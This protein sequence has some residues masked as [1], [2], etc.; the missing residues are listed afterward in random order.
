MGFEPSNDTRS[1]QESLKD[2]RNQNIERERARLN[3]QKASQLEAR[4]A[5]CRINPEA[6]SDCADILGTDG[7]GLKKGPTKRTWTGAALKGGLQKIKEVGGQALDKLDNDITYEIDRLASGGDEEKIKE[8][9]RQRAAREAKLKQIDEGFAKDKSVGAEAIRAVPYV[10]ERLV[11]AVPDLAVMGA[12]L[13]QSTVMKM[14]GQEVDPRDNPF[15]PEYQ[16]PTPRNFEGPQ[17]DVG[18]AVADLTTFVAGTIAVSRRLPEIGKDLA[19]KNRNVLDKF[20]RTEAGGAIA[21]FMLVGPEDDTLSTTI[22]KL[23]PEGPLRDAFSLLAT[24]DD[25]G[26]IQ[27][28][29]K[30][31]AEGV[32]IGGIAGAGIGALGKLAEKAGLAKIASGAEGLLAG[33][34]AARKALKEGATPEEALAKGVKATEAVADKV[35]KEQM[36][37]AVTENVTFTKVA[38]NRA[39]TLTGQKEAAERELKGLL[40]E[41]Q[42]MRADPADPWNQSADEIASKMKELEVKIKKLDTQIA[43]EKNR[44]YNGYGVADD[45]LDASDRAANMT[46]PKTP[47]QIAS[48]FKATARGERGQNIL[49]D[50]GIASIVNASDDPELTSRTLKFVQAQVEKDDTILSDPTV[51]AEADYF[52]KNL[53][54]D[55]AIDGM[56]LETFVKSRGL[57]QTEGTLTPAGVLMSRKLLAD[58]SGD[59]YENLKS[60]MELDSQ[61][62]NIGNT[63]RRGIDDMIAAVRLLQAAGKTT[64][65]TLRAF[66]G[67]LTQKRFKELDSELVKGLSEE[68]G[69]IVEKLQD[70]AARIESGDRTKALKELRVLV[71]S[72]SLASKKGTKILPVR[73][74]LLNMGRENWDRMMIQ[75]IFSAPMTQNRN[76]LGSAVAL[77]ERPISLAIAGS[78]RRDPKMLRQAVAGAAVFKMPVKQLLSSFADGWNGNPKMASE[79]SKFLEGKAIKIE[80]YRL[81]M[82]KAEGW[83][84]KLLA[85]TNWITHSALSHTLFDWPLKSIM[86]IDEMAQLL[87]Y[88]QQKRMAAMGSAIVA[89]GDSGTRIGPLFMDAMKKFDEANLVDGEIVNRDLQ[90]WIAAGAYQADNT[91]A[92][93]KFIQAINDLARL[94]PTGTVKRQIPIISTPIQ[95]LKHVGGTTPLGA[96][97]LRYRELTSLVQAGK[98]NETQIL[99]L[100]QLQGRMGISSLVALGAA[101]VINTIGSENITG[102]GPQFGSSEAKAW[103][104]ANIPRQSIRINGVWVS[105]AAL[106]P[107]ATILGMAADV[108]RAAAAWGD[109]GWADAAGIMAFSLSQGLTNKTSLTG[110]SGLSD[111]MS[112]DSKTQMEKFLFNQIN[113][114]IPGSGARRAFNKMMEP[115]QKEYSTVLDRMIDTSGVWVDPISEEDGGY[116]IDLM[117]GEKRPR[118]KA[119]ALGVFVDMQVNTTTPLAEKLLE[120]GFNWNKDLDTVNKIKLKGGMQS[121]LLREMARLKYSDQMEELVNSRKFKAME[122]KEM[123]WSLEQKWAAADSRESASSGTTAHALGR[124]H[125]KIKK[126]AT[127]N[128]FANNPRWQEALAKKTLLQEDLGV[129]GGSDSA[130]GRMRPAQSLQELESSLR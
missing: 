47:E 53:R 108:P 14:L 72:V 113:N 97:G 125:S 75:S 69:E 52:M 6:Y 84:E 73:K 35:A 83:G 106:D 28:K 68:N 48:A 91:G 10:V 34:K 30:G 85:Q 1:I 128:L 56:D 41:E 37:D 122:E 32:A 101:G 24:D 77:V 70:L 118:P 107:L 33:R 119:G 50:S 61:G 78:V 98:A 126:Q 90:Q 3:K 13:G 102:Y 15:S 16:D 111:L 19:G 63:Y 66:G 25:E 29:L 39:D 27:R 96:A 62:K 94:D 22:A 26:L 114:S 82:E 123:D 71:A 89:Q 110:I 112:F 2:R 51:Y 115:Y 120:L 31:T 7:K 127:E 58:V 76:L 79:G 117:T 55:Q 5:E 60:L 11:T 45:A 17:T 67:R 104:A 93:K 103:E 100:A 65:R 121:D 124:L 59:L 4:R 54:L 21:D 23:M 42:K 46:P 18:K 8:R 9:G 99:E 49:T 40:V 87:M 20:L 80:E 129:G 43:L 95:I 109:T 130:S 92:S 64:G 105:Y 38:Q 116:T 88:T 81:A 74:T 57:I 36:A 12:D 86:G 44:Q